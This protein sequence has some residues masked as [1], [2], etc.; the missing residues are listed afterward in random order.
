MALFMIE[1]PSLCSFLTT[2][3]SK[4]GVEVFDCQVQWILKL[5][6]KVLNVWMVTVLSTRCFHQWGGSK[7]MLRELHTWSKPGDFV[8]KTDV[9]SYYSS[10]NHDIL[11]NQLKALDWPHH[12][13]KILYAYCKRTVLRRGPS[14]HCTSGIPKGGSLSPALGALYLTPLDYAMERWVARGDCFYARF[15]D[16]IILSSRKRHTLR[17]MRKEMFFSHP[18]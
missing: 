1:N 9:Y 17:R 11:L 10:L 7:M 12:L 4:T 15:Q 6:T 2:Y 8:Y 16:D 18:S 3:N 5:L 14:I 13:L